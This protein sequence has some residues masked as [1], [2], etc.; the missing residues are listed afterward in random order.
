MRARF[1]L[2]VR[3][4][5]VCSD[6]MPSTRIV[7]IPGLVPERG[8][9]GNVDRLP[10]LD[11]PFC[12]G[13]VPPQVLACRE[14]RVKKQLVRVRLPTRAQG[15]RRWRKRVCPEILFVEMDATF[16]RALRF[17]WWR[18]D[19]RTFRVARL[20]RRGDNMDNLCISVIVASRSR[21][22]H[23]KRKRLCEFNLLGWTFRLP[24]SLEVPAWSN[25]YVVDHIDDDHTNTVASNLQILPKADHNRKSG[26]K[27][28][29]ETER[30][31]R[32]WIDF[33]AQCEDSSYASA[34]S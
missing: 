32:E 15:G 26:Q 31:R 14:C 34:S 3:P 13:C 25:D 20:S 16:Q 2:S 22:G 9:D 29:Q 24:S 6:D 18:L 33:V 8:W 7:A 30:R 23:A 17:V 19:T 28:G 5:L 10:R 12:E 11:A 27:G 4:S 1:W 21:R